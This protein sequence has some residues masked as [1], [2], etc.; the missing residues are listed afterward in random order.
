MHVATTQQ[1]INKIKKK[2]IRMYHP[3]SSLTDGGLYEICMLAVTWH[4]VYPGASQRIAS[5]WR[6]YLK[7]SRHLAFFPRIL[8]ARGALLVM[9]FGQCSYYRSQHAMLL[10]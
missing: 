10:L 3:W 8:M 6:A 7:I 1:Q 2:H 5:M 4:R 9:Y